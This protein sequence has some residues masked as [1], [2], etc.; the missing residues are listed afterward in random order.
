[1]RGRAQRYVYDPETTDEVLRRSAVA[2]DKGPYAI[3][4]SPFLLPLMILTLSL[5]AS[6][7]AISDP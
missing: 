2:L 7:K 5:A 1:M 4:H 6:D 3:M